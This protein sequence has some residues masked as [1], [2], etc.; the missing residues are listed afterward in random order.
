MPDLICRRPADILADMHYKTLLI[1]ASG[2]LFC[3]SSAG[4]LLVK[5]FLRPKDDSGL[6]EYYW[7]FEE[8][9]PDLKRYHRWSRIFFTGVIV[10]ML[11]LF[12]AI[13]V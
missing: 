6:E 3:L 8:S 12:V 1:L 11:L 13:S 5:V 7:E 9:H 2:V 10:S 4:Y